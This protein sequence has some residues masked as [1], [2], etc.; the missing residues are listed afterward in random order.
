[1]LF[2]ILTYNRKE[3]LYNLVSELKGKGHDIVIFDDGSQWSKKFPSDLVDS[4]TKFITNAHGG[5]INFWKQWQRAWK[6]INEKQKHEYICFMPDDIYNVQIKAIEA[7]TQ[8]GWNNLHFAINLSNSGARYRWGKWSTGQKDFTIDNMLIQECG[9]VDGLFL[10]NRATI[11][12]VTI[13]AIPAFWFDRPDKSS[14]VGYQLSMKFR[15]L[16]VKMMI[17]EYSYCYHG[18]HESVMHK[19]HRIA[20]PLISK[21]KE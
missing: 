10:T 5:K 9:Y 1:M 4:K 17:P 6:Y 8:Q 7:L 18:D 20:V 2:V 21:I 12:D 13:D 19:K 14:G 16:G 3:M 11:Q 15:N